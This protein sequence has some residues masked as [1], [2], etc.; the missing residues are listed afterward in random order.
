MAA[1]NCVGI[2][3]ATS[4]LARRSKTPRLFDHLVGAQEQ[5]RRDFVADDLRDF[6]VDHQIEPRRLLDRNVGRLGATQ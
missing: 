2:G 3:L 6:H 4:G 1:G 5:A